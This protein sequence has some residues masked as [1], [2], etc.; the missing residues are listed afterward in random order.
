MAFWN[1]W[2]KRASPENPSTNLANPAAWLT[3]LFVSESDAGVEINSQAALSVSAVWQCVN[4]IANDFAKLP[5]NVYRI[6][7]NEARAKDRMHPA[8]FL[9]AR[10]PGTLTPFIFKKTLISHALLWGNGYAAIFRA[11]DGTPTDLMILLPD[12]TSVEII[13]N[14]VWYVTRIERGDGDDGELRYVR[15]ENILHLR[16]L[17]FDGLEGHSIISLAANTFGMAIAAEKFGNK[18]FNNGANS[19]GILMIPDGFSDRARENLIDSFNREHQGLDNS[20]KT[21]LLENGAKYVQT[22]IPPDDAQFLQTRDHQRKEIAGWFLVPPSRIGE[23]SHRSYNS[24]EQDNRAYLETTLDPWL[25]AFE[26]ECED[27]LLREDEKQSLSHQVEFDRS[28]LLRT[29]FEQ[30]QRGHSIAINGGWMT[31]NEAR[32]E[33]RLP[34]WDAVGEQKRWPVNTVPAEQAHLILGDRANNS[35]D[36]DDDSDDNSDD[37]LV[38]AGLVTDNQSRREEISNVEFGLVQNSF[39][40]IGRNLTNAL[41]RAAKTP[42]NFPSRMEHAVGKYLD[43]MTDALR[44]VP[45]SED[46]LLRHTDDVSAEINDLTLGADDPA[47]ASRVA[48]WSDDFSQRSAEYTNALLSA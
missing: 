47:V 39:E 35:G 22:T 10:K 23:I 41:T 38:G 48:A 3:D 4:L 13:D 30:K 14:E 27:K 20:H 12:R 19:R 29:D 7:E 9:L 31:P 36:G 24:L 32:A 25:C 11:E 26:E 46:F 15:P 34:S 5:L 37:V 1:R 18:F 16:G 43:A 21:I 28:V 44:D 17:G 33:M 2:I 40:R 45:D 6:L 8:N 42:N